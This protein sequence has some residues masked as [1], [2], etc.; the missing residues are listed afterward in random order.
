MQIRHQRQEKR[1]EPQISQIH[2]DKNLRISGD[3]RNQRL[4]LFLFSSP[5]I[6]YQREEKKMEPL[7]TQI[8]ADKKSKSA[9]ISVISG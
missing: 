4:K 7:I 1:M 9:K 8:H 6:L 5:Q 3:Q 2:A